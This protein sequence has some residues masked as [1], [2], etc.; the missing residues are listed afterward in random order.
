MWVGGGVG[1]GGGGGRYAGLVVRLGDIVAPNTPAGQVVLSRHLDYASAE[2]TRFGEPP[3]SPP[4]PHGPAAPSSN[5]GWPSAA[6]ALPCPRR[7]PPPQC[8]RYT[9]LLKTPS[10]WGPRSEFVVFFLLGPVRTHLLGS[11][12]VCP[13]RQLVLEI[14]CSALAS[15]ASRPLGSINLDNFRHPAEP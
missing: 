11:D 12:A 8:L 13:R 1:W 6:A 14:F 15:L 10:W 4:R 7:A 9:N 2:A 5:T 3:S